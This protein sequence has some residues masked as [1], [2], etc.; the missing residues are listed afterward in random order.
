M[1]KEDITGIIL[2][3]GKSNRLGYEKGLTELNGQPL[4]AYSIEI[5]KPVCNKIIISANNHLEEYASFGFEVVEDEIKSIGPMGGVLTCLKKSVTRYN[6]IL[7]CDTP[8]IPSVLFPFLL[9]KIENFQAVIPEH[10]GSLFEPLSA[11]YAT[12][13]IWEL[14]H[15]VENDNYKMTDFLEKVNAKKVFIDAH[16]P[17]YTDD[18][19]MNMNTKNDFKINSR[20]D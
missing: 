3:G 17:F 6:Y 13:V 19:F 12:N 8:F 2:S 20:N 16:L 7:S 15:C 10:Q 1:I 14:Q 5:L 11:V 4:I 9:N 18:M